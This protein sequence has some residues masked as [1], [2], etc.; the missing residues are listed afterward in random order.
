VLEARGRTVSLEWRPEQ[1]SVI[2]DTEG[3]SE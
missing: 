2:T 3:G 1:E